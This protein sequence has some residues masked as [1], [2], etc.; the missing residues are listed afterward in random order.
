ML[1]AMHPRVSV[2]TSNP[3]APKGN[4]EN[5][6]AAADAAPA[7]DNTSPGTRN[8]QRGENSS[9]KRRCRQPSRQGFRCGGRERPSLWRGMGTSVMRHD[10]SVDLMTI[11]EA[12]FMPVVLRFH[13]L[14]AGFLEARTAA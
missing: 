14:N 6:S 8:S 11:S 3:P 12:E 1:T 4:V 13:F 10:L 9:M 2:P 7:T 5:E